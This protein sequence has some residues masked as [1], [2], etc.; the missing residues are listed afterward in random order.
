MCP[1]SHKIQ[2][3]RRRKSSSLKKPSPDTH[4]HMH[5]HMRAHTY[6]H[7][8]KYTYIHTNTHMHT[9]IHKH[10]HSHTRAHTRTHALT[11]AHTYTHT[12]S[13]TH[14]HT[15][16]HTRTRTNVYMRAHT[17]TRSHTHTHTHTYTHMP[18][19]QFHNH[20]QQLKGRY[21]GGPLDNPTCQTEWK[22]VPLTKVQLCEYTNLTLGAFVVTSHLYTKFDCLVV[23]QNLSLLATVRDCEIG[24]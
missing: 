18:I 11:H 7:A 5:T 4:A 1:H 2:Q 9:R 12:H 24:L 17:Y 22:T 15:H 23:Y 10:T 21:S 16:M 14:A 6:T 3:P 13:H 19:S 20:A 8:Q